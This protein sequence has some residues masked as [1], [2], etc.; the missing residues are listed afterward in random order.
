MW[1]ELNRE[2]RGDLFAFHFSKHR[3]LPLANVMNASLLNVYHAFLD[4]RYVI[5]IDKMVDWF[6]SVGLPC[7]YH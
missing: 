7:D 5:Q 2:E 1:R 6:F 4:P 3:R